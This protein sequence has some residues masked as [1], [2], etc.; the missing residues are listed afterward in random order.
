MSSLT[1]S[2]LDAYSKCDAIAQEV[3]T[4]IRTVFAHGAQD[5][6]IQRFQNSF[7]ILL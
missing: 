7:Q 3:L 6:E 5:N 4:S 2:E 1:R